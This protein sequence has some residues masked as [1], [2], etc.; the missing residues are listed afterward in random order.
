MQ[1]RDYQFVGTLFEQIVSENLVA[2]P[3]Y[4]ETLFAIC[5]EAVQQDP[6][7]AD[8]TAVDQY[9]EACLRCAHVIA[10]ITYGAKAVV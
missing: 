8:K 1:D 4:V 5:L 7:T 3:E 9:D 10:V 6:L 2:T